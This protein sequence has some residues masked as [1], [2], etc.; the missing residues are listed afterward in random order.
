VTISEKQLKTIIVNLTELNNPEAIQEANIESQRIVCL[1]EDDDSYRSSLELLLTLEN[2]TVYSFARA[3]QFLQTKLESP[4]VLV[5]DMCLPCLSGVELQSELINRKQLLPTIFITAES[6]VAQCVQAMKHNPID[7][8]VKPFEPQQ[9]LEAIAKGFVYLDQQLGKQQ[10]QLDL[11]TKLTPRELI[12]FELMTKGY[13]I[14]QLVA[15]LQLADSTIKE[16]KAKI[17]RK[18]E[19]NSLSELI[20]LKSG[21]S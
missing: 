20:S 16:Y 13:S 6:T 7:F 18:L 11:E 10:R 4:A 19:A 2:Y 1:I 14:P 9:L 3:E 5:T 15:E 21:L 17:F 12:V 8:L